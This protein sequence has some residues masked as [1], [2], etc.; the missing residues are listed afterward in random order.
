M[1]LEAR[2][3]DDRGDKRGASPSGAASVPPA[4][5]DALQTLG[6]LDPKERAGRARSQGRAYSAA[7]FISGYVQFAS[8][9]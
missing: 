1:A 2:S 9:A 3:R 7:F 5:R 8:A 6:V 4:S